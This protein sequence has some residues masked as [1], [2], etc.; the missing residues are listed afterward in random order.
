MNMQGIMFN[1]ETPMM[2]GTWYNP[3]T[4]DQFTVRNTF[5]ENNQLV[6]QT[7]DGRL[8]E[9]NQLQH[10]VQADGPIP[11]E[12]PL[13]K[14]TDNTLPPEVV[15]LIDGDDMMLMDDMEL[16]NKPLGNLHATQNEIINPLKSSRKEEQGKS[17]H[18]YTENVNHIIISKALD[19]YSNSKAT[20]KL[21]KKSLPKE[22]IKILMDM[23]GIS[24]EDI[25]EWYMSKLDIESLYQDLKD[26]VEKALD[27]K[28]KEKD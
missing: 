28:L 10:Y 17:S 8:L 12:A 2:S 13:Q 26:S 5:F 15:G 9:Y 27:E 16:I 20:V 18:Q 25:V 7:M 4:K 6:V 22:P 1:G 14:N 24:K 19:K 23:M 21:D 11:Q 3:K